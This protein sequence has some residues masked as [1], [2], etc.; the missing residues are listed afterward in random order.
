MACLEQGTAKRAANQHSLCSVAASKAI[1]PLTEGSLCCNLPPLVLVGKLAN[2]VGVYRDFDAGR[3]STPED[4]IEL[5]VERFMESALRITRLFELPNSAVK[6]FWSPSAQVQAFNKDGFFYLNAGKETAG[7]F[8]Y[9]AWFVTIC[10]ELA[11][12]D[13]R[14]HGLTHEQS[15]E[16]LIRSF[17]P[18]IASLIL[19]SSTS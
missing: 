4:A 16:A 14:G 17:L 6:V 12:S 5:G 9:C 11:H 15:E 10:H 18:Q 1:E 3:P 2:G 13:S 7:D 8:D 19:R